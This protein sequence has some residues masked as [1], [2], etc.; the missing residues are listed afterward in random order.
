MT[1]NCLIE[2]VFISAIAL[3]IKKFFGQKDDVHTA[4]VEAVKQTIVMLHHEINN[5]L[6]VV[7]GNAE[8]ILMKGDHLPA[9]TKA[10]LEKI[11]QAGLKIKDAV[12]MLSH[13]ADIRSTTYVNKVRMIDIRNTT[14]FGDADFA[15]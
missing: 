9:E 13:T 3:A 11:V 5:P 12:T 2:E 15:P 4:Q 8:L 14:S 7:L 10:R 1:Y 6:T